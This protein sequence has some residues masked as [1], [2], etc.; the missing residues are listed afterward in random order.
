MGPDE[1]D[2]ETLKDLAI[3]GNGNIAADITRIMLKDPNLLQETDMPTSV[4]D[5]LKNCNLESV[6]M[7]ARRGIAEAAFSIKE[8]KEICSLP[9]IDAYTLK[10]EID[11]SM[12]DATKEL[13]KA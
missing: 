7:F 13:M 10:E 11:A 3:I 9:N 12:T 2:L 6:H 1:L 8:I 4:A 5:Q